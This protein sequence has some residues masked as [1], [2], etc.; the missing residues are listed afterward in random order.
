MFRRRVILG[1]LIALNLFLFYKV[2][3]SPTGYSLYNQQSESIE[4]LKVK[5]EVLDRE[6]QQLSR[7]VLLLR[8]DQDYLEK[9]VRTQM[10]FVKSNEI[11]YVFTDN[12]KTDEQIDQM[13]SNATLDTGYVR[14]PE[15]D[16][17][18]GARQDEGKN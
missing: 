7:Q 2:F 4:E 11:L 17:A 13:T 10:K 14:E 15:R 16:E 1:G 9:M 12:A 6:N 8:S 3:F 5:I 18:A